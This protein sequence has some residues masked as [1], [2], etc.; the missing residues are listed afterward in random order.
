VLRYDFNPSQHPRLH[1][2]FV[3]RGG[4]NLSPAIQGIVA[5]THH[6]PRARGM[7]A[8]SPNVEQHSF[9]RMRRRGAI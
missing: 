5:R 4:G 2:K 9:A 1:G 3:S 7:F 6:Y 8:A